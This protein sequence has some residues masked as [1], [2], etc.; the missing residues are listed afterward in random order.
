MITIIEIIIMMPLITCK[1][2]L[3]TLHL[4]TLKNTLVA[5]T[6][7]LT[8]HKRILVRLPKGHNINRVLIL[9]F[10]SCVCYVLFWTMGAVGCEWM[11][12]LATSSGGNQHD[13]QQMFL[14]HTWKCKWICFFSYSQAFLNHL[15]SRSGK[16]L[17]WS[18]Q[19]ITVKKE[20]LLMVTGF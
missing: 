19:A 3:V 6:L 14:M 8:C 20:R 15:V 4:Q 17:E 7:N 16:S 2:H 1:P 11:W 9:W 10:L 5:L 18:D 13:A 12:N